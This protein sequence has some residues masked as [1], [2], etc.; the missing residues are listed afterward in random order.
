[1]NYRSLFAPHQLESS[2]LSLQPIIDAAADLGAHLDIIVVGTLMR[3]TPSA[4]WTSLDGYWGEHYSDTVKRCEARVG[5]V[6]EALAAAGVSG[7][8]SYECIELGE[9]DKVLIRL[10]LLA[11]ASV[12]SAGNV[13][14]HDTMASAFNDL[15]LGSGRPVLLLGDEARSFKTLRRIIVAW[16]HKRESARALRDSLPL[17]STAEDVRLVTIDLADEDNAPKPDQGVSA[18]LARHG[19][20]AEIDNLE[21]DGLSVSETLKAY[22]DTIEADLIVMG[23]YGHSRL[24]EWLLGGTTREMLMDCRKPILMSH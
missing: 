7:E 23:A 18:Y 22:A 2:L 20:N 11:D 5:A 12:F 21:T 14:E 19:I 13:R 16:T 1:M 3:F 24:R 4:G 8:V 10:A 9:L 15:L 6:R 17:L